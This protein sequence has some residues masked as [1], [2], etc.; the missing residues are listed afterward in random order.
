VIWLTLSWQ[1]ENQPQSYR[2]RGEQPITIGSGPDCHIVLVDTTVSPRHVQIYC[3]NNVYYLRNL[4]RTQPVSVNLDRSL[5]WSETA[6]LTSGDTFQVGGATMQVHL[7][8]QKLL[9]ARA[10]IAP[11]HY[12]RCAGC[13]RNVSLL[14][15]DCPW[16]GA[17]LAHSLSL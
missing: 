12:V 15:R 16:C 1:T 5:N 17:S 4:S 13:L 8:Q 11:R 2:M 7:G 3:Q 10:G 6:P 14:L 9:E